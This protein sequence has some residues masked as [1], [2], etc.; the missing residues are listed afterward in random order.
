[1]EW[2]INFV[3]SW[4]IWIPVIVV[5]LFISVPWFKRYLADNGW[6]W[7]RVTDMHAA[8][9]L[10]DKA[11]RKVLIV[12]SV[13]AKVAQLEKFTVGSNQES[14]IFEFVP[15]GEMF[16]IGFPWL[17][18]ELYTWYEHSRDDDNP[19]VDPHCMLS[20][21]ERTWD[22]HS[23]EEGK[24]DDEFASMW[25]VDTAD[26]IQVRPKLVVSV[27]VVNPQQTLFG[28][29]Y[30]QE[31][32]EKEI[33]TAWKRAVQGLKYFS[34]ESVQPSDKD[35][36]NASTSK[37][38]NLQTEVQD[39]LDELLGLPGKDAEHQPDS[40]EAGTPALMIYKVYGVWLKRVQIRDIDPTDSAIRANLQ[41]VLKA[42]T[43]AAA[44]SEEA[45]GNRDA[46]RTEA[47]GERDAT[48]TKAD[49]TAY[50][51]EKKG[52]ASAVAILAELNARAD[53]LKKLATDL[54]LSKA[55]GGGQ[56]L[57]IAE[58]LKEMFKKAGHTIIAGSP[59]DITT[60]F[61]TALEHAKNQLKESK[62]DSKQDVNSAQK[63]GAD[64]KEGGDEK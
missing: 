41:E 21:V 45:K 53:G 26:P 56:I 34:Y 44:K 28:V 7:V 12:C 62:V 14:K 29:Q 2:I 64:S 52:K 55:E 22:Y 60:W 10:K 40:Y 32:I 25:G 20:L 37:S 24:E 39:K 47:E 51:I 31:A 16:W 17:G 9:V 48:K 18:N 3:T 43:A 61:S 27:E 63:T 58:T 15:V 33:L 5:A 49:G 4:F 19:D 8:I 13:K 46:K 11:V 50:E 42:Q 38:S 23:T 57:I 36:K 35:Q 1:M 54:E 59:G 30:F 6:F